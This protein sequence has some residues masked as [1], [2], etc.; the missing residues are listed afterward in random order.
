ML[1]NGLL[2]L[3]WLAALSVS[4][5]PWGKKKAPATCRG[6]GVLQREG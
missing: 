2:A 3:A 5:S 4:T 1:L 6:F